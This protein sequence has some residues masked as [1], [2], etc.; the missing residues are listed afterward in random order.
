VTSRRQPKRRASPKEINLVGLKPE[1][2]RPVSKAEM[3]K[4]LRAATKKKKSEK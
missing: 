2:F 4:S 1:D 3:G